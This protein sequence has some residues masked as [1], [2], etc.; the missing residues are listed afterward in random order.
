[1]V[2]MYEQTK[3]VALPHL[4]FPSFT[5]LIMQN[6]NEKFYI[7]LLRCVIDF[8]FILNILT[9]SMIMASSTWSNVT[10]AYRKYG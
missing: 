7:V 10:E 3:T 8:R 6:D 4:P 1:M 2:F 5:T 9:C